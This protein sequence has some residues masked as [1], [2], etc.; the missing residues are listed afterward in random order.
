MVT[1]TSHFQTDKVVGG[2][3]TETKKIAVQPIPKTNA[4]AWNKTRRKFH[5]QWPMAG[6]GD[7]LAKLLL[8][9]REDAD[10]APPARNGHI[11]LLRVRRG[12]DGRIGEQDVIHRLAL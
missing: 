7:I 9:R 1:P 6:A 3:T 8:V 2:S 11:P 12:L 10:A 5:C 4:S